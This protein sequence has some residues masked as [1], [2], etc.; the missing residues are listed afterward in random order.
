MPTPFPSNLITRLLETPSVSSTRTLLLAF[1][2]AVL[3]L[4]GASAAPDPKAELP[5]PAD[6]RAAYASPKIEQ[7]YTDALLKLPDWNG[8][9]INQAAPKPRPAQLMF[10]PE[11]FFQPEF[12]GE[13]SATGPVAGSYLTQIPYKPEYL[14]QYRANVAMA[15]E[16]KS[17]DRVG[18]LCQPYGGLRLMGGAPSG[19]EIT[20][21]PEKVI[22]Y[23][24]TGAQTRHIYTDGRPHPPADEYLGTI[25]PRWNGH[26]I[27]KWEGD[28][29]V[30]DT[31]GF[32][33]AFYDQTMPPYSDQVHVVERIRLVAWR[34]LENEITITDPVM[35]ERPWVVTRYYRR[36]MASKYPNASDNNC[37]PGE[38]MDFSQGYQRAVLPAELEE[39][40]KAKAAGRK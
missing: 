7:E 4:G 37:P 20:I 11:H 40:E 12:A 3:T 18:A 29:L 6:Q 10:D 1:G 13:P 25:A 16:G 22:M 8:A 19:P 15:L 34:W 14:K 26:S 17:I 35:L 24:D 38:T 5:P 31:V 33:P 27:G 9:W 32:Y 28:T 30:V 23:F 36:S 2:C 39:A 21:T